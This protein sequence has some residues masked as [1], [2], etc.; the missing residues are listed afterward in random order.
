MDLGRLQREAEADGRPC[1]VGALIVD[2][3]GR[4]FVHRRAWDRSFLPGCWDIAGGHV[5][6]GEA[7]LDALAREVA[8]ET[9]WRLTGSP[10]LIYVAD[11]LADDTD[12]SSGRREFD[13]LVEVE[14]DLAHPTLERP[15]H[16]EFRW[17]GARETALLDENRGADGG[18]IR[19]LAEL[20]LGSTSPGH[21]SHTPMSLQSMPS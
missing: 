20:A 8:E 13:F 1:V 19:H 9:G 17:L 4:V 12:P 10:Q 16:V 14:G 11:W 15:Q 18:L 3:A 21:T 6:P 5:E 7:L 2:G